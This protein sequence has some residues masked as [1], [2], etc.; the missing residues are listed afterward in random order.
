MHQKH[1]DTVRQHWNW[2]T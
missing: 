1:N 2:T